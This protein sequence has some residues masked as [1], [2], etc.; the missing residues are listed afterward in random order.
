MKPNHTRILGVFLI[1]IGAV[2]LL[3]KMGYVP[4]FLEP[5]LRWY[6]LLIAIGAYHLATARRTTGF[7]L[8]AIGGVFLISNVQRIDIQWNLIWPLLLVVLGGAFLFGKHGKA[9]LS[10]DSPRL[11]V[12][13][14]L[15]GR[16][17]TVAAP[18]WEGGRI[19]CL[20]GSVKIDLR[21]AEPHPEGAVIELIA[22]MGGVEIVLPAH[23]EVHL[24]CQNILGGL[25]D[26][27]SIQ[28]ALDGQAPKLTIRGTV[29]MGGGELKSKGLLRVQG[30]P[31]GKWQP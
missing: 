16:K 30:A 8:I 17:H 5:Y 29:L 12:S 31:F 20:L 7:I 28:P 4:D 10:S 26:K 3:Q 25:E 2:I 11:D 6:T 13:N 22:V 19:T 1:G 23:W 24:E 27:R 14:L 9:R 18:N 15:G 21:Q